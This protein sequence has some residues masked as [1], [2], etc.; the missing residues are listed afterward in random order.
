MS[1]KCDVLVVGGGP[2]GC[3]AAISAAKKGLKTV[4]IEEHEEIG[5]PIQCAEGIGAYLIPEM[6]F[7]IPKELL[8]WEIAGMYFWADG[9]AVIKDKG[10]TY[11]GYSID[12][13]SWDKWIASKAINNNV[14]MYLETKL[15]SLEFDG[16]QVKKAIAKRNGKNIDFYPKYLIGADG[17]HSTVIKHL[18][19]RKRKKIGYV[20][21]Y[22]MKNLKLKY[23]KYDQLFFGDF[24]PKA[25]S[26]IFPLSETTAN[27][28][29]GTLYENNNLEDL[30]K[31]FLSI[32]PL[33]EQIEKGDIT[34]EKSGEVP[35][36][37]ICESPVYGNIFLVGDAAN[38]NIKPFIEGN[39]PGI[40][41]GEVLGNFIYDVYKGN[42]NP[43]DYSEEINNK[44]SLIQDSQI[45][46]DIVYG[47]NEID[48]EKL[49]I[50]IF[51]VMSEIIPLGESIDKYVKMEYNSLKK[52]MIKNGAFIER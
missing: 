35:I 44:F 31:N 26:Y 5:T 2:A 33:I 39:I 3:S 21:S 11:A 48:N 27:V 13:S 25:Y 14:K 12:R 23:P 34:A 24:A 8:K 52:F 47:D 36:E 43:E 15:V 45:F 49:K 30:F 41:C 18:D 9:L 10:G 19:V 20:K 16:S 29:T 17:T 42:K 38:Q 40:I 6:P 37:N 22:E 28:G 32:S 46:T 7:D 51:G 4:L 1:V 50:L